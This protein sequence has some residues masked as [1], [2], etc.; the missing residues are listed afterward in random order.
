MN[1][2]GRNGHQKRP[3][4]SEQITRLDKMLD[5]LA[6]GLNEAVAAAVKSA[7]EAAV[8]Q[9]VQSVLT[10]VLTN[11]A[12]LARLST[13]TPAKEEPR[14]PT[15]RDRIGGIFGRIRAGLV[16]VRTAFVAGVRRMRQ[17]LTSLGSQIASATFVGCLRIWSLRC[18][19]RQIILAV[20]VGAMIGIAAWYSGPIAASTLSGLGAA[21]STVAVQMGIWLRRIT[22]SIVDMSQRRLS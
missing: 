16:A 1:P 3:S 13:P 6:D 20:G 17:A 8:Q 19:A 18:F 15:I 5:G 10:E 9:T 14:M 2:A 11:P 12:M 22:G 7:V 21:G 4:L